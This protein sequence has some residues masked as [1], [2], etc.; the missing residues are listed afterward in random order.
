MRVRGVTPLEIR[1]CTSY[2][3]GESPDGRPLI[4]VSGQGGWYEID[5]CPAYKPMY[6][7]MCE[8]TTMFYNM[9]DIYTDD[10]PRK[11]KKVKNSASTDE[12]DQVFHKVSWFSLPIRHCRHIGLTPAV[13][14]AH[15]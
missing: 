7:K 8:A 6:N 1:R 4:W 13:R 14:R 5:P 10:P 9:L 12:L 2:S 15:W 11:T 3:I